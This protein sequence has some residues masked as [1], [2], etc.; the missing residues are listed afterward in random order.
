ELLNRLRET[1]VVTI[2]AVDGPATG[3]GVG[4]AAAC[5]L[6]VTGPGASFRL[7]EVLLGL[8]PG[9]IMPFIGRRTGEQT[10]LRMA[11]LAETVDPHQALRWGLT[12][13]HQ[14]DV[15]TAVRQALTAISRSDRGTLAELKTARR[16]LFPEAAEYGLYAQQ[17]LDTRLSDKTVRTRIGSLWTQGLL[18]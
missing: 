8:L 6:A 5:D 13:I 14:D 10:L 11:T 7:T 1:P 17:L 16:M 15:A 18:P 2:A 4:L 3:G 12:D 9:M